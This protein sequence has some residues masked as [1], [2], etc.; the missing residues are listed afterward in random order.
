MSTPRYYATRWEGDNEY[1]VT[2]HGS[3]PL[4][5]T[6]SKA[7][8]EAE[9]ARLNAAQELIEAPNTKTP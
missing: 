1:V 2:R 3:Q 6:Y 8:A 9:A 5:G 4:P 7:D